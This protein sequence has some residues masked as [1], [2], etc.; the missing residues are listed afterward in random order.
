MKEGN[1]SPLKTQQSYY[2]GGSSPKG[3]KVTLKDFIEV[4]INNN[5]LL[6]DPENSFDV[7]EL[8]GGMGGPS[9]DANRG[10]VEGP[11]YQSNMS[12]LNLYS[13]VQKMVPGPNLKAANQPSGLNFNK[14]DLL[15]KEDSMF[16]LSQ[17]N[18]DSIVIMLDDSISPGN[19]VNAEVASGGGGIISGKNSASGSNAS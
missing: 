1:S 17:I 15:K 3:R 2:K 12:H 5:E 19:G 10:E 7:N 4:D 14:I 16:D 11:M 6:N 9:S 8:S 13:S 18:N